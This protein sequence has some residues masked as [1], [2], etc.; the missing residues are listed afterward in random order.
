ME[1]HERLKEARIRAGYARASHAADALGVPYGT[2]S[3]HESGSRGIKH[4][5][6]IRYSKFFK[7]PRNWLQFGD[8]D[9]DELAQRKQD[10]DAEKQPVKGIPV[11]GTTKAGAWVEFEEFELEADNG[12][13]VP[14][15]PGEWEHLEQF[16]YRVSGSSMDILRIFD[17]E[18]VICVPYFD[19]RSDIRDGDIVVVE[20]QK[21]S[22]VERTVKQIEVKGREA[23]FCPRSSNP[24]F[25]PIVVKITRKMREADDTE[26][27]LAGLVI[28]VWS[29]R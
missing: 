22:A 7:V 2:Y 27:R 4:Q 19:A 18:Y 20:R 3:G 25:K 15:V 26:V 28:G 9:I 23:H 13:A 5:D 12:V 24:L 10:K 14:T 6:V 17:G 16:A 8:G 11:R 1:I 29:P 21:N